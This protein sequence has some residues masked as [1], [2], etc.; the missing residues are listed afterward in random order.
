MMIPNRNL[1]AIK[2]IKTILLCGIILMALIQLL[3]AIVR[4]TDNIDKLNNWTRQPAEIYSLGFDNEVVVI[5]SSDFVETVPNQQISEHCDATDEGKTCLSVTSDSYAW[6]SVFDQVDVLQNPEQTDELV[7][8]SMS[9]F[10]LPIGVNGL[11]LLFLA[12]I[13][14][15]LRRYSHWGE[16]I[17]WHNGNWIDTATSPQRIGMGSMDAEPI[18]ESS[19]SR[20]A[21]TFWLALIVLM[22]AFSIPSLQAAVMDDMSTV[23]DLLGL[24]GVGLLI[25]YT[26][27]KTGSRT[28]YQDREGMV[29][30]SV[31]GIKR[32]PWQAIKDVKLINLNQ[33]AQQDYDR[34]HNFSDQRPQTLNV[35]NVVDQQGKTIIRLSET[36]SPTNS[37]H[38]LLRRLRA[39]P[40]DMIDDEYTEG[41]AAQFVHEDFPESIQNQAD[42]EA[43]ALRMMGL[44]MPKRKSIFH[45]EHRS[46]LIGLVLMLAPFVSLTGYLAYKSLWFQYLAERT[47]G[48][49]IEIKQDGLPSLVVEYR[50][51]QGKTLT[52]HSDGSGAYE[53]YHVGDTLTVFYDAED[54]ENARLNVFLELWLGTILMGG[55]TSIVLL[56]TLLIGRGLTA[57]MPI[58]M[59]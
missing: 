53:D 4:V 40:S 31:F 15:W 21:V 10:W 20:N 11:V 58:S 6:L 43:R 59:K 56:M 12:A 39:Q 29:D 27:A 8:A 5:T 30:S 47:E 7:I 28:L 17:T 24:L 1:T 55:L 9:G 41:H 50:T 3:F 14:I 19:G 57:P 34:D 18:N 25:V 42:F 26:F 36:M 44:S 23:L 16:D 49:I 22:A 48:T 54:P 13:W 37:F 52:T 35:Y 32:I 33:E 51:L 46:L 2:T 38:A 45:P